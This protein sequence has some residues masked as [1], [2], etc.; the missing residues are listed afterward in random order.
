MK[1]LK[2]AGWR[3]MAKARRENNHTLGCE[4]CYPHS[5][6]ITDRNASI[7]KVTHEPTCLW[8]SQTYKYVFT[9]HPHIKGET[10][11]VHTRQVSPEDYNEI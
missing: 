5:E 7:L 3:E 1:Y 11:A 8:K 6:W 4:R 9:D 2:F 10:L